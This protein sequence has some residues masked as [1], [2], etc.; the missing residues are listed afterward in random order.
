MVSDW[1]STVNQIQVIQKCTIWAKF[2][3]YIKMQ[4]LAQI[5][6]IGIVSRP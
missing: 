3:D 2:R 1:L 5:I 6:S 4:V